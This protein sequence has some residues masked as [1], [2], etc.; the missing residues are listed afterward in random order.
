MSE[1][2]PMGHAAIQ[3][4]FHLKEMGTNALGVYVCQFVY[5][6]VMRTDNGL[7]HT[8]EYVQSHDVYGKG[9]IAGVFQL[10][11]CYCYQ[12][13]AWM[14]FG[15]LATEYVMLPAKVLRYI[16]TAMHELR[17]RR[18][19]NSISRESWRGG[20]YEMDTF[21]HTNQDEGEDAGYQDM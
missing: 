14:A 12:L 8:M 9:F 16:G 2:F 10:I 13:G 4:P 11:L 15:H 21:S 18:A 20:V 17:L 3:V 6:A 7:V 5:I 1:R 19:F